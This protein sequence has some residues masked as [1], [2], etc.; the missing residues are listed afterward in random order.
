MRPVSSSYRS[1]EDPPYTDTSTM[2]A[3]SSVPWNH[4]R[5]SGSKPTIS[6]CSVLPGSEVTA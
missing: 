4:R 6:H 5:Y 3:G 1:G 2:A